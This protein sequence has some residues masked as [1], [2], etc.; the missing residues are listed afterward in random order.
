[1]GVGKALTAG[2]RVG[3]LFTGEYVS[4]LNGDRVGR[5][6]GLLPAGAGVES[7]TGAG[8][9]EPSGAAL[10]G[11][12]VGVPGGTLTGVSV[13]KT[14]TP[15]GV[16]R[17]ESVG[18]TATGG[19]VS[20]PMVM[21]DM[22]GAAV[23]CCTDGAWVCV[24]VVIVG[25]G[26]APGAIDVVFAG[27]FVGT[28]N[29]TSEEFDVGSEI[30]GLGTRDSAKEGIFDAIDGAGVPSSDGAPV[31]LLAVGIELLGADVVLVD[32]GADV[33]EL[34]TIDGANVTCA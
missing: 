1:M 26:L 10:V 29:G 16:G 11:A 22:D 34:G 4:K 27:D 3:S 13:G 2:E 33:V 8:V 32:D 15:P 21:L 18:A 12:W 9:R 17:G 25:G 24:G 20:G 28:G 7:I 14:M 5:R 19:S 30:V 23:S 6:V 31:P